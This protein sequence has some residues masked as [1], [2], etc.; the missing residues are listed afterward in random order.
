MFFFCA[1]PPK[2]N[3]FGEYIALSLPHCIIS[4]VEMKIGVWKLGI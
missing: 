1:Y 3:E 2:E 4:R